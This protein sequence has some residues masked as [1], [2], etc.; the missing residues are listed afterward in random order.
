MKKFVLIIVV[1]IV[2]TSV[3][4]A[5]DL[6]KTNPKECVVLHD[7]LGT[8]MTLITLVPGATLAPHTH[9]PYQLYVLEGGDIETQPKGAAAVK[10]TIPTGVH[11]QAAGMG[12]HSDKNVGTTTIKF[13]LIEMV[14]IK[15]AKS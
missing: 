11:A 15:K 4:F 14:P 7:T 9:S 13:L 10:M 8:K 3:S 6:W 1:C 12:I 5:Q 2:A